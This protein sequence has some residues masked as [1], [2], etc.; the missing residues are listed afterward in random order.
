MVGC[1]EVAI[2]GSDATGQDALDGAGVELFEDLGTRA[3]S[4]QSPDGEKALLCP[5]HDFLGV[6][7]PQE[8]VGEV[9]TKELETLN[10]LY[11]SPVDVNGGMFS[12]PFP[13]VYDHS[14][15]LLKLRERVLS[16]HHTA[17]SLTSSL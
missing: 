6:F 15:V 2:P 7:G 8:S 10:L 4:F 11:Y 14:F 13:V 12:T 1:Q 9:V 17:R 5:R 16:W 3:K